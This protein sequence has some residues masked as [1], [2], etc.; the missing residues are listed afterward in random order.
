MRVLVTGATGYI[1]SHL[2]KI[3]H[4]R[5]HSVVGLDKNFN[6]NKIGNYCTEIINHD[7][8]DTSRL[9]KFDAVIHLAGYA[10]VEESM[11]F[12]SMYYKNNIMSTLKILSDYPDAHI[13]FA[14]TSN[15]FDPQSPYAKSK[16]ACED[17]IKELAEDYTIFRFFNVAG[18]D[19]KNM[20]MG[21]ATH[22]IRIASECAIGKRDKVFIFGDDYDTKDGTC[23]R[24]Y[25]H[26]VDIGNAIA[27]AVEH[28]PFNTPYECIGSGKGYTVLEVLNTMN[29]LFDVKYE[30]APRRP[31]DPANL[32]ID[33]QFPLLEVKHN[34]LDM[35]TSAV[36]AEKNRYK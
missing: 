23:V 3:L 13:L 29:T 11:Q 4:D 17:I 9:G 10:S 27:N 16:V 19:G 36:Q 1:G 12:P 18:S 22:L 24:D 2:C 34:L 14:S 15:A 25:I 8:M 26:V 20:Q 21:N 7:I 32:T 30:I 6:Q 31:G 28:G 35:C 33:N 5:G